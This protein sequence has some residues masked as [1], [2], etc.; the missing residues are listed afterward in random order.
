MACTIQ[1]LSVS[2]LR[3][4]A[5]RAPRQQ[6]RRALAVVRASTEETPAATEQPGGTYFFAGKSMS[7][8]EWKAAVANGSISTPAAPTGGAAGASIS[9]NAAS[10]SLDQI[11]AFS[12]P[13]PEL[14]NGRLAMLAFV[15]ALGAEL[16]TGES[17]LTQLADEPTGI[18]LAAITFITASLIPMLASAKRE[19][20][21]IFSPE[22]EM[23][24]G[25]AA[26]LGFASLI[27]VEAVRGAA[28]F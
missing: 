9:G 15:A 4:A 7:E 22:A 20:F 14:I 8:A 24:N 11:M 28:L 18:L 16:S 26:M 19:K 2:S 1:T 13:A 5:A 3:A 6:A 25:R 12:G 17:V 23:L 10:L 21:A 27:V